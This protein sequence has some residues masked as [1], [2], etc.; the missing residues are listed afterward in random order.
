MDAPWKRPRARC[1]AP[2][3]DAEVAGRGLCIKHYQRVRTTGS[4][5]LDPARRRRPDRR[6]AVDANGYRVV[7]IYPE[8]APYYTGSNNGAGLGQRVKEHRLVMARS[9]GRPL[10]D[11]E[12]VH[13]VNGD[14]L[15]NR[16]ENLQL[17]QGR[18]GKGARFTCRA[19]GSHDVEAVEL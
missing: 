8:D 1:T 11:D 4:L 6:G 10:R 7:T 15:D 9:L 17:R 16:L 3:C 14:K 2:G 13:H 19:C 5:D 18:H 12:T